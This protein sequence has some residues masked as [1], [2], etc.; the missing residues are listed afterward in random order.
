MIKKWEA[1]KKFGLKSRFSNYIY[2]INFPTIYYFSS[3]MFDENHYH[4]VMKKYR[5]SSYKLISIDTNKNLLLFNQRDD[6]SSEA[7]IPV[8]QDNYLKNKKYC[9]TESSEDDDMPF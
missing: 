2:N 6:Q 1:D 3:E 8:Y 7:F 4:N 9:N 5:Y